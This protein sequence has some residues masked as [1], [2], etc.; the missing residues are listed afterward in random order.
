MTAEEIDPQ[1]PK[2][3]HAPGTGA[4]L[5][6]KLAAIL[7][8]DV[9]GYSRLSGEREEE[10][11]RALRACFDRMAACIEAHNGRVV[12]YAGDA[13]LADFGTVV[14]ALGCAADI[15]L[16]LQ[17]R[18][19][20]AESSRHMKFRIGIN[21]GDVIVDRDDLYG[22]GV[23]VAAR[24]TALSQPGE[25]CIA[26]SVRSAAGRKLP[27]QYEFIGEQ[28]V[29][30]ILEPVRAY[31]VVLDPSLG[32]AVRLGHRSGQRVV[33]MAAIAVLVVAGAATYWRQNAATVAPTPVVT[34]TEAAA[35]SI[36]VL[37]FVNVGNDPGQEYFADGITDDLITGLTKISGLLVIARDSSFIYKGETVDIRQVATQLNVRYILEGSVRREA[38]TVRIN[39]QLIDAGQGANLWAERYDGQI[40]D[41]FALQDQITRKIIGA[42]AVELT[43]GERATL[44]RRE[45]VSTEA[46]QLFLQGQ[47]YFHRHSKT[48]TRD[49][50]A[51][52]RKVIARDPG[53]ARA[54][55]M[56]AMTYWFE[57]A[58]AWTDDPDLSLKR[59]AS[60]AAQALA[61]NEALPEAHFVQGLVYRERRDYD[62]ALIEAKRAIEIDPNYANGRV[63][64]A[65]LLYYAGQAKDGLQEM[66][67]AIRLNPHHP[68]NYPFHLG[69]AYFILGDYKK[70]IA[71]FQEGL[72]AN[73]TSERMRLWLASAYAQAGRKN[74][75]AWELEV[76]LIKDPDFS[77]S[78]IRQAYP[79]RYS[80]DLEVFL[81]G[82]RKAGLSE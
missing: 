41:V 49:A 15:Q 10:T 18:A 25:I 68:H 70:A 24:L 54:Y 36:A 66:L 58:N 30:N 23:N 38:E 20:A 65:T 9:A 39:A 12:N 40:D 42:L 16:Q 26:E 79:F 46:Y 29:K 56:Y 34:R 57:F 35:H 69:Q 2:G 63:L 32:R 74:E 28:R 17:A 76:A 51:L 73:P 77:L 14:D 19:P 59:A 81:D 13:V 21:L 61:L 50:Q 22:D 53:F 3:Q 67:A 44:A 52:F 78:R 33:L 80:A 1:D 48:D 6:R 71:T 64:L 11:H 47:A 82:L 37:P 45:T 4:P 8:A 62:R 55:A 72:A 43:A 75:A 60:L 27:L 7:H 5:R 31:R